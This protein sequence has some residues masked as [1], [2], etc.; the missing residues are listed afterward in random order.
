MANRGRPNKNGVKE[1]WTILRR[2]LVLRAYDRARARGEKR[3]AA[4]TDAVSAVRSRLP[5]MRISETEVKRILA[6]EARNG[7]R[8]WTIFPRIVRGPELDLWFDNLKW[9]AEVSP[10]KLGV[11]HL[12]NYSVK[13]RQLG[14]FN[15]Q[16]GPGRR[17][18]RHN[19]KS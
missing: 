1:A 10:L 14:I 18:P 17:Y 15:I 2:V 7:E 4:I 5:K 8:A 13:P 6:F 3:S 12:P 16:V 11:P 19:A 9:I